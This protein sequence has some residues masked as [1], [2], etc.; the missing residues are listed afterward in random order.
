MLLGLSISFPMLG[1]FSTVIA[2]KTFSVTFFFS[3]SS[4]MPVT[5]NVGVFNIVPGVSEAILNSFHSFSF[6]MLY[7]HYFH[8]SIFQLTYPFF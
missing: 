2:S 5:P 6:I 3:S 4:G 8:H 7:S 1:K